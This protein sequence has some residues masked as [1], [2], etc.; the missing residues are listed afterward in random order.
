VLPGSGSR[1]VRALAVRPDGRIIAA[2]EEHIVRVWEGL[3]G[4]DPLRLEGHTNWVV[5][6]VVLPDGRIA[7]AGHDRTLRV[8]DIH[9]G[10]E[11]LV[12]EGHSDEIRSLALLP[13]GRIVSASDDATVRVW[14]VQLQR[15]TGVFVADAAVR[16]LAV[17]P[18]GLIA[19]GC[20]DGAVHLLREFGRRLNVLMRLNPEG[21]CRTDRGARSLD[22]APQ[23]H[24]L[25]RGLLF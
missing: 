22:R 7:T 10:G 16:C 2:G 12:M 24:T 18:D 4:G 19:A 3:A 25:R 20:G 14:D 17:A 9:R 11:P 15:Q 5:A 8:W 23:A 1:A 21:V 6:L 13:D